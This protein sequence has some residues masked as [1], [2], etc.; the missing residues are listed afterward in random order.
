MKKVLRLFD[1]YQKCRKD[2]EDYLTHD[3]LEDCPVD[4]KNM[5]LITPEAEIRWA[6]LR[7][8]QDI[9]KLMPDVY[10]NIVADPDAKFYFDHFVKILSRVRRQNHG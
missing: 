6:F 3:H 2:F 8:P 1:N 9:F 7:V 10:D 5:V 4:S